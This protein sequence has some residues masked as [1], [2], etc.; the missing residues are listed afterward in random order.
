MRLA[1]VFLGSLARRRMATLFSFIAIVLGVALGMAVQ[2]VH[3]AAL[4][5]FGRGL[6]ALAGEADLQVVGPRGGFDE[7][8]YAMLASRP[9]VEA[10]S[11]LLE[12]EVKRTGTEETLQLFGVDVFA[13]VGV[14]PVL[15]PRPSIM[16]ERFATLADD[17]VFLSA[18]AQ[19]ALGLKAGDS[20]DFQAGTRSTSFKIAGDIPGAAENRRLA[21]MDI[22]A[23]QSRFGKLG[24]LTRIDLRLA[25]GVPPEAARS[26]LQALLPAGVLIEAPEAA[27]D[28]A[29]NLSRAYR[30]NLTMLA[31]IALLTGGFLVF[32]AQA[33]SV[34]RRRTEFAFLRALGLARHSLFAWLLAEGALVGLAG[35][36]VGVILGHGLAWGALAL[37]GGD[38][39]AGYFSGLQ[40]SLQFQ[41]QVSAVYVALGLLAG[42]AGAWLP[43]RE[44]TTVS[45]AQALKAGD[46]AALLGG[47]GHPWLGLALLGA[48][49]VACLIPPLDALPI[50][51]YL[52]VAFLLAGGVMLLPALAAGIAR[53]LPQRGPVPARLAAARLGAAPGHAVVA[54][55]G[56]L[57][58]VA[59]AAA[60]AIMVASFRD[61]VDQ[62]LTQILPADL[63]L[64]AGLAKSSGYLDEALQARISAVNG[65]D[66]SSFTRHDNLRL[67]SGEAPVALIA[68]P[69]AADG[70]DLPLVGAVQTG[71][72]PAIWISEA[73]H[74]IYG[75]RPGQQVTLPL[76][77]KA[78]SLHVAGVWRDYARQTG[79]VMIDLDDYR[80]LTGDLLVNDAAI[81]LAPGAVANQVAEALTA[82]AGPGVLEVARPGEIRAISLR[83]FDRTFAVTYLLEA[84]AVAIGLAGVAASFAALA[85]A[86]RREFGMLRHLGLTRRQIG[87]M[88]AQEGALAAGVGVLAG[89]LAGGAIGLVLIEVVNRQSFHWSMDLHVPWGS[90]AIFATGLVALA[91]LAA[92]LAGRQ[93]MRQDAVLAVREDW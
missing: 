73:M 33:L 27:A 52:A 58:S 5:E 53:L 65:V 69:L 75:W 81:N 6:R 23:V 44:A 78:V 59:L 92:V 15:L 8:L 7:N 72:L 85:S 24:R 87:W 22:A 11:P 67:V 31:A 20:V 42:I 91:A 60:M 10:A 45:P 26:A 55:A 29:A 21:L 61:S 57:T 82:L 14:T 41:P 74:D 17:S 51:G 2:A 13:L 80:R 76:A 1:P 54:A 39:G 64:R 70:S 66:R 16:A 63:Y 62:W 68:R 93:A 34:V 35:G 79:A 3:E 19:S 37:L 49:L 18:A 56:V 88:L 38:L 50:G 12:L 48:S 40:P 46:E 71:A 4:N 30:V 90:L 89:L 84:V 77:G 25:E 28:Q 86:R 9:E 36:L 83:I 43:A 47:R 32:S